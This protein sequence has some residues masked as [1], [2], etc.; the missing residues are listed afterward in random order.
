M[1]TLK[2]QVQISVDGYIA[3]PNGKMDWL[4]WDWDEDLK[5]FVSDLT[6]TADTIILGR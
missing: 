1:R 3:G 6:E 4:M 2:L 5:K